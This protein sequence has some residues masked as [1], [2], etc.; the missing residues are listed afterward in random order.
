MAEVRERW[1]DE[2]L[3]D[4]KIRKRWMEWLGHLARMQDHRLPKSVLFGWLRQPRPWSGPHSRWRNVA[5]KNLASRFVLRMASSTR[6]LQ[7]RRMD[8]GQGVE[9]GLRGT[10]RSKQQQ[11]QE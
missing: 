2:E 1:G 10:D 5:K 7:L 4:E 11:E 6:Q 8:R 9:K 3:V